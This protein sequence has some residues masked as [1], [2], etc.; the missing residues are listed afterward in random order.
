MIMTG[1]SKY[2]R[3]KSRFDDTVIINKFLSIYKYFISG[4]L[5][6]FAMY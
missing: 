5:F 3:K 2:L 6:I 1:E 4:F